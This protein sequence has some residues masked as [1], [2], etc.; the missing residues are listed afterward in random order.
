MLVVLKIPVVYL[1]AVVWWAIRAEPR[2]ARGRC[3]ARVT[4]AGRPRATGGAGA[5]ACSGA[6][7]PRRRRRAVGR[8]ARVALARAQ[9]ERLSVDAHAERR[10]LDGTDTVAGL[11]ATVSI[12]ASASERSGGRSGS[13][14]SRSCSL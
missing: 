4:R 14:R 5:P 8:P 7:R 9:G 2:A 1:C 6:A 10:A 3:A 13:S 11:L 12:F